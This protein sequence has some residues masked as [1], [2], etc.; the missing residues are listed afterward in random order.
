MYKNSPI[1]RVAMSEKPWKYNQVYKNVFSNYLYHDEV[2]KIFPKLLNKR[3][4]LM[5]E[6][7]INRL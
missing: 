1:L 3:E 6:A 4:L 2:V 5:L 7:V